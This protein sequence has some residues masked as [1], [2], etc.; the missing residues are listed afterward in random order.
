[1]EKTVAMTG[2]ARDQHWDPKHKGTKVGQVSP[3]VFARLVEIA[4]QAKQVVV[5]AEGYA[6]FCRHLFFGSKDLCAVSVSID[7]VGITED[8][9]HLLRSGYEA[10]RE[11][12]LPVLCRWFEGLVLDPAPVVDVI[13]YSQDQLLK[14]GENVDKAWGVVGILGVETPEEPPPSPD[15]LMRN[16]LGVEFGGSGIPLDRS[17]YERSVEYW[18]HRALVL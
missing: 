8:N 3:G 11:E 13:L 17:A 7:S 9:R 18:N 1:M 14:E 6:P 5:E 10:R 16:A 15:I 4:W 12:E 2:F